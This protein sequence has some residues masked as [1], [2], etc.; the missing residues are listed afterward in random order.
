MLRHFHIAHLDDSAMAISAT[1]SASPTPSML[2][3]WD[4]GSMLIF[5][6]VIHP[7]VEV[8]PAQGVVAG[9]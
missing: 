3:V 7:V 9:Y 4:A 1:R 2:E 8:L 5:A 6:D